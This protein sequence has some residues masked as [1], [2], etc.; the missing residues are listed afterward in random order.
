MQANGIVPAQM[1]S[2]PIDQESNRSQ[3]RRREGSSLEDEIDIAD[4]KSDPEDDDDD[5]LTEL[6]VRFGQPLDELRIPIQLPQQQLAAIQR[7][8]EAK[9]AKKSTRKRKIK[10]EVS[11]IR[12]PSSSSRESEEY[13]E[14]D[15]PYVLP[16]VPEVAAIHKRSNDVGTHSV[17]L[18]AM[19][20][21]V[22]GLKSKKPV[23]GVHDERNN[24]G[25]GSKEPPRQ[26]PDIKSEP[27]EG[28]DEDNA[29]DE[30]SFLRRRLEEAEA[31]RMAR[32]VI[33]REVAPIR[34]PAASK[35]QE[36]IHWT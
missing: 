25:P 30:V 36:V 33:K 3:K 27:D 21:A 23:S 19:A 15:R 14:S 4:I 22:P 11:P 1:S 7:R 13:A 24:A 20:I 16:P 12:V 9:A 32:V 28:E 35:S 10:R 6:Q 26:D 17:S 34:V 5:D 18:L 8:I 29:I 31:G 2:A